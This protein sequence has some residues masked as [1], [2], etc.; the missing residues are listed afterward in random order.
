MKEIIDKFIWKRV[1]VEG[2]RIY[3]DGYSSSFYLYHD[4][5]TIFGV[6]HG[7]HTWLNTLGGMNSATRL[8]FK[9][10]AY[11]VDGY[12]DDSGNLTCTGI[13]LIY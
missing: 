3:F 5:L 7:L 11:M 12:W 4:I 10:N 8:Y 13:S 2:N 9:Y 1:R 6:E